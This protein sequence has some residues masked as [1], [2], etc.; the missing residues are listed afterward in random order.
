MAKF[1]YVVMLAATIVG[2]FWLEIF[3]KV[4]VLRRFK[5]VLASILP[6]AIFFI[7]WDAYAIA[8]AHWS[9]DPSQILGIYGPLGIPIEEFAFFLI[10]PIAGIMTIEAVRR[11]KSHWLM[12]DE[13]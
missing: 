13:K 12:G 8:H 7:L 6:V 11:V 9:F 1:G 3:L 4:A 2:S 10:I 5:R